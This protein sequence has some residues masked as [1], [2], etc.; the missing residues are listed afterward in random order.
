MGKKKRNKRPQV[1]V[2]NPGTTAEII[3]ARAF[4]ILAMGVAGYLAWGSLTGGP[5]VG[6]GPTSDCDKVLQSRWSNWLGVP[7]T[8]PALIAYLTLVI[9][10]FSLG[11]SPPPPNQISSS[12]VIV[13]LS[14]V[15][16]GAALWF[17]GIQVFA[18]KSFCKFCMTAH[19][20]AVIAAIL[21]LRN[22]PRSTATIASRLATAPASLTKQAAMKSAFAGTGLLA[23]LIAGQL[24]VE[25]QRNVVK[26]GATSTVLDSTK[27]QQREI[28]LHDGKF[29][30]L[31]NELPMIGSPTA[32]NL[33]VSLFD[34]SC[35]YC[36][37]MHGLLL[38]AQQHLSN[39]LGIV[40]LPMPLDE[41]CN[42][43]M[44]GRT[45]PAHK[46]ACEYAKLGL[47]VWRAK[48][49]VFGQFD[50][51]L[52]APASPLPVAEVKQYAE[53]L[54]GRE[55]LDQALTNDWVRNQLQMNIDIWTANYRKMTNGGMPQLMIGSAISIGP[56]NRIDQLYKMLSEHLGLKINP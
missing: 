29:R 38:E 6:C 27:S 15:V 18:L 50:S 30:L 14:V 4:L 31:V 23:V 47:A 2:S 44:V 48:P 53:Q 37:E 20:S 25:K 8:A 36:R 19:I 7:V 22:L 1:V 11:K 24:L 21:L 16:A 40:S 35:H 33:M 45:P 46:N 5:L 51:W 43:L 12:K 17:V 41:H 49:E 28:Q 54:V 52:F 42:P 13:F 32:T 3:V 34:Y 26:A 10:S 9:A 55:K 56:L 39:Q